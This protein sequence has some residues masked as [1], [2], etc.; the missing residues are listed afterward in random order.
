[1]KTPTRHVTI[2]TALLPAFLIFATG[3]D[4]TP[5]AAVP[6]DEIHVEK[7]MSQATTGASVE[8]PFSVTF[9]DDDPCTS[10]VD[11]EEH[12]VTVAGTAS[13]HALPN[14]NVVVRY[15]RSVTTDSGYEGRGEAVE[16]HNGQVFRLHWSD[17]LTHP[18]GRMIRAHLVVVV[19]L[20]TSPPSLRVL[21]GGPVRCIRGG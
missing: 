19:D 10:T 14:G 16:V 18:D 17:I 8:I 2:P 6:P 5:T 21:R 11:P 1:M 13:S 12:M 7:S 4:E 9:P 3:C 15:R 20:K